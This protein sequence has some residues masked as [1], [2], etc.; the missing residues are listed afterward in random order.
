MRSSQQE[1]DRV[2]GP[3]F[4]FTM[5]QRILEPMKE[6]ADET[7]VCASW[8]REKFDTYGELDQKS[9][10][11]PWAGEAEEN[12]SSAALKPAAADDTGLT[13]GL[14]AVRLLAQDQAEELSSGA[15]TVLSEE[16]GRMR[17]RHKEQAASI[18]QMQSM[19]Q[20]LRSLAY[21]LHKTTGDLGRLTSSA[22]PPHVAR[23]VI[24]TGAFS[25]TSGPRPRNVRDTKTPPKTPPSRE[26]RTPP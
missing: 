7:L 24:T 5:L 9:R 4:S 15:T 3:S 17:R 16:M 22:A 19:M 23:D 6:R 13:E 8:L 14:E 21:R 10:L 12:S 18:E 20:G 25:A 26:T 11:G 1:Y 2:Y